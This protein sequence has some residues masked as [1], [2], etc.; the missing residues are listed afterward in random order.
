[1]IKAKVIVR[2]PAHF[3]GNRN[4]SKSIVFILL[5]ELNAQGK[6][7]LCYEEL[8]QFTGVTVKVLERLA[9]N[10]ADLGYLTMTPSSRPV[11]LRGRQLLKWDFNITRKGLAYI[12]GVVPGNLYDDLIDKI[13]EKM[14]GKKK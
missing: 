13:Q 3:T 11:G 14:Q 4:H 6:G 1:M 9:P 8:S 5:A 7:A 10:W 12:E 2:K